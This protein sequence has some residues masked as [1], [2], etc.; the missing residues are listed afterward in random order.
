M[1]YFAYPGMF[2]WLMVVAALGGL[3]VWHSRRRFHAL[4]VW[5]HRPTVARLLP[6]GVSRRR[7]WIARLRILGLI[8]VVLA[9]SG[10]LLGTRL[11]EFKQKGMDVFIAVDTS[12][13]MQ[14][15]DFAPS[16]MAHAKLI[17][18][19]LM[20]RLVGSRVG[21]I[22]FAGQASVQCP[23]T[24][25]TA[26]AKQILDSVDVGMIP[27]PGT[28]IG[29]A[30]RVAMRGMKAGEGGHRVL[31]LL[32]DGEDHQSDPLGAAKEAAGVGLTIFTI[33]IGSPQGEPIPLFDE[34]GHRV[35]Y[36]RDRKGEVV[37]SKL[38][39]SDLAEIARVTHGHF[40]RASTTGAEVDDVVRALD[41]LQQGDQKTKLFDR[42][43]NRY[44]W[45]LAFGVLFLLISLAIPEAGWKRL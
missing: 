35:G 36:K 18:G 23:L 28:K 24:V 1:N 15:Q 33:G 14:T 21:I 25:D 20:E 41:G 7:R 44:Q 27:I 45:P 42:Y 34:S 40:F 29:E 38:D 2:W 19:Q 4:A 37:I 26:A 32:T 17:L 9:V 8:A 12:L 39:E 30:I 10:P 6:E 11:V 3:G 43:E 16:R 5:G 22:G 31:I 13:S